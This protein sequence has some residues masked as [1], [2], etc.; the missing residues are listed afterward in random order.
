M[1]LRCAFVRALR[2]KECPK[3]LPNIPR[4]PYKFEKEMKFL[5]PH[6][7]PK[8]KSLDLEKLQK[9]YGLEPSS[10]EEQS[11]LRQS[12]ISFSFC[13]SQDNSI[14][15]EVNEIIIKEEE[16]LGDSEYETKAVSCHVPCQGP[17]AKKHK[18]NEIKE[19]MIPHCPELM[20]LYN[21]ED[22][23]EVDEEESRRDEREK[24]I[25]ENHK[26]QKYYDGTATQL[27]KQVHSR[28][29]NRASSGSSNCCNFD[30]NRESNDPIDLF[31]SLM[32]TT[33]KQFSPYL[34]HSVKTKI[35]NIVSEAEMEHFQQQDKTE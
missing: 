26:A 13:D 29:N 22:S 15:N 27:H 6:L 24:K 8:S 19:I 31:F 25:E 20:R 16:P 5:I 7:Q 2:L 1:N 35:F 11:S 28:S 32:A 34:K 18:T 10:F 12:N 23:Q 14:V 17:P 33:V 4:K 3:I 9:V 21:I 30:I